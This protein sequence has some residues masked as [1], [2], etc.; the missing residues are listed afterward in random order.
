[1]W[2]NRS[3]YTEIDFTD[4]VTETEALN[5]PNVIKIRIL[6]SKR[7]ESGLRQ[8]VGTRFVFVTI[9]VSKNESQNTCDSF[10]L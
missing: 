7:T 4:T 5:E 6:R 8:K 1:M 3:L 10:R 2:K 9:S